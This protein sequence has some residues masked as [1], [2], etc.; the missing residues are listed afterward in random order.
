MKLAV[1]DTGHGID[2]AIHD[3]IFEPFFTT[4]AKGAGTG[5]GLAVVHGIVRHHNGAIDL[6][7]APGH[8]TTFRVY[9]P[10]IEA[11]AVDQPQE[12]ALPRGHERILVVDDE[13]VLAKSVTRM[14]QNLGYDVECRTGGYE[15][16]EAV[17]QH[18]ADRP[19][20]LVIT[21]MTMPNLTGVA[22]AQELFRLERRPAVLLC[23]GYSETIDQDKAKALG[24]QGFMMKPFKAGALATTVRRVLDDWAAARETR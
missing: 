6:T 10:V 23:T 18:L 2:P 24:I 8:G 20:E 22:L 7:S 14:L 11:R 13:V 19:F 12:S 16:L 9:L 5:L 15:G 17:R 3:R 4:K 1:S 21:D